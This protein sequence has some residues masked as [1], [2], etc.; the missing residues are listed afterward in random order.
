MAALQQAKASNERIAS[1]LPTGLVAVFVGGTNGVGE[2]TLKTFAQYA[3]NPRVY[4]V[5]RSQEAADRIIG[6][7]QRLNPAG[8]FEFIKADI[9]ALK[10]VDNFTRWLWNKE[11]AINILFQSQG[12]MGFDATTPDG[13]PLPFGLGMHSRIR[14]MLNLLPLLQN[15]NSLRRVVSV[16]CG[17]CEGDIDTS[18]IT[19]KGL[20]L[21][22]WRDQI[23]SIHT[24]LLEEIARRAPTISFV[25]D[26]PGIVKSGIAR[27]A[28]GLRMSITLAISRLLGSLIETPPEECGEM[29]VFFATSAAFPPAVGD[30]KGVPPNDPLVVGKGSTGKVGSGVYTIDNKGNSASQ[31]VF[32]V[33]AKHRDNGTDKQVWDYVVADFKRITGSEVAPSPK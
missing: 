25:H 8:Y 30:A 27:D 15:A 28:R 33:L 3:S 26:V 9:G 18:N 24:L 6:E 32:D 29:H 16:G 20:P 17:T 21:M 1:E 2:Y 12:N 14:F 23:A 10:N 22:K 31:K 19:A 5:G 7:C 4:L 11:S 13:I